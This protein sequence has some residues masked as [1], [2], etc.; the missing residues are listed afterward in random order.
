[1][2]DY[3]SI[4]NFEFD[5]S[6]SKSNKTRGKKYIYVYIDAYKKKIRSEHHKGSKSPK[7]LL[8]IVSGYLVSRPCDPRKT[9]RE[10]ISYTS[11]EVY[12]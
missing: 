12:V 5:V 4:G 9:I 7:I 11:Y 8:L 3:G 1:M 2:K 6:P 10:V